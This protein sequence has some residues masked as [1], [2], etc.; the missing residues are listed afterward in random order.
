MGDYHG[1]DQTSLA[2]IGAGAMGSSMLAC[3]LKRT[4]RSNAN[5]DGADTAVINFD[6]FV[7]CVSSNGSAERLSNDARF[8]QAIRDKKLNIT[9]GDNAEA[10]SRASVILLA[11]K[12]GQVQTL[13]S[14]KGV[15]EAVKGKLVISVLAGKTCAQ[16]SEY[17]YPIST[18]L[19]HEKDRCWIV[20]AMPSLAAT[21]GESMTVL[22]DFPV[23]MPP[24]LAQQATQVLG[25]VGE[26]RMVSADL[27]DTA[28]VVVGSTP[29]F[30]AI[31]IDGILDGAVSEGLRRSE[32]AAMMAQVL[33]GL[34]KLMAEE[35]QHLGMLRESVASP[36]G[37]TIGGILAL[38]KAAARYAFSEAVMQAAARIKKL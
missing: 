8:T 5:T 32:A 35:G 3:M 23:N 9:H 2:V 18:A 4:Q 22:E 17:I 28:T 6:A 36:K 24:A 21:V 7:A 29:A 15:S 30:L 10:M 20:R 19:A 37:A 11:C 31:G 12:P 34:G 1:K 27:F 33:T 25:M 26:V 16:L 14:E 38:E 13:L